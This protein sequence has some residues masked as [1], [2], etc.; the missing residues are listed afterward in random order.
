MR[1]NRKDLYI[2][3]LIWIGRGVVL[4]T[5]IGICCYILSMAVVF[6]NKIRTEHFFVLLF[7]PLG[8]LLIAWIYNIKGKGFRKSGDLALDIINEQVL[9]KINPGRITV[10]SDWATDN[11]GISPL[12]GPIVFITTLITHLVGGSNGKEG[13]GVQIG[14][15]LAC[16]Q[17]DLER[18][19]FRKKYDPKEMETWL[20]V[21]AGAAFGALFNAPITGT[22][23]GLHVAC[24]TNNRFESWIPCLSCNVT[25]CYVASYLGIPVIAIPFISSVEITVPMLVLCMF[26]GIVAGF[27]GRLFIFSTH[28]FSR[29]SKKISKNEY[30]KVL[31][32]SLV[33]TVFAVGIQ[34]LTG[35]SWY[36]GFGLELFSDSTWY[37]FILK[38][39][40]TSMATACGFTGGEVVPALVIGAAAFR[41][42]AAFLPIPAATLAMFGCVGVLSG[43]SKL[44][45]VGT[46]MAF[47]VFGFTNPILIFIVCSFSFISSGNFSI[48][49][50]QMKLI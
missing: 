7:I 35:E 20:I 11:K 9:S 50:H 10:K 12:L 49:K 45:L 33:L 6:M 26:L 25:S 16:F 27:I 21:G 39:L 29:L 3:S 32:S 42:L 2:S 15:S 13:A 48:Y 14:T 37:S 41:P 18:R 4:G 8:A 28:I 5:M 40:L 17:A 1:D 22:M 47:E 24:P 36:N 34:L 19:I 23:F 30:K 38:I 31:I 44:P 46:L 43:S